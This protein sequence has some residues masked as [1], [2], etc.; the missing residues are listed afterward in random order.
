MC[1]KNVKNGVKTLICVLN[2]LFLNLIY[3]SYMLSLFGE[4]CFKFQAFCVIVVS[5]LYLF[6]LKIRLVKFFKFSNLFD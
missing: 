3:V 4:L 6:L 2:M 5:N 1:A